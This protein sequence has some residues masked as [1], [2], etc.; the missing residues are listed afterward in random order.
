[1][2]RKSGFKEKLKIQNFVNSAGIVYIIY[3]RNIWIR[4]E[5]EYLEIYKFNGKSCTLNVRNVWFC[6]EIEYQKFRK[7]YEKLCKLY[8]YGMSGYAEK[9]KI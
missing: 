2:Y 8:M 7:L 5:I 4:R 3:V 6:G 9:L 1:M